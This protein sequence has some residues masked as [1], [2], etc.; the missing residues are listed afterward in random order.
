MVLILLILKV[1][2][3]NGQRAATSG[4]GQVRAGWRHCRGKDAPDLREGLQQACVAI[5]AAIH[6]RADRVGDRSVSHL[7][8]RK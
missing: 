6:A 3:K 8:R 7:Q 2:A 4:A 1:H 5:A